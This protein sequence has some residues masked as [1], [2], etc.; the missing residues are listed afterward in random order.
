[1]LDEIIVIDSI[2]IHCSLTS[3][4]TPML[5]LLMRR[6]SI[7]VYFRTMPMPHV[8]FHQNLLIIKCHFR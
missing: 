7:F 1:M 8:L 2:K 5:T 3:D 6:Q 4:Y